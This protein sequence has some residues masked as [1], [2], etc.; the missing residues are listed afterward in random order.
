MGL[1]GIYPCYTPVNP[2][3]TPS[4]LPIIIKTVEK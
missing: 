2:L 3:Q 1:G 4:Y